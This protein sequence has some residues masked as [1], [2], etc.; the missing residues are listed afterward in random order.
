MYGSC[1]EFI[2]QMNALKAIR[3]ELQEYPILDDLEKGT[4]VNRLFLLIAFAP[5]FLLGKKGFLFERPREWVVHMNDTGVLN[6]L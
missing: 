1:V 2:Q 4:G 5:A 6:L 3:E